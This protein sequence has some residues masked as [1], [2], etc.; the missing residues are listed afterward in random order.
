MNREG[1]FYFSPSFVVQRNQ[2]LSDKNN[3]GYFFPTRV[4][5]MFKHVI[6]FFLHEISCT[7]YLKFA[8]FF[9]NCCSYFEM[10]LLILLKKISVIIF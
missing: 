10:F 8:L 2:R 4:M 5:V 9:Y 6:F 7:P 1:Y 3:N